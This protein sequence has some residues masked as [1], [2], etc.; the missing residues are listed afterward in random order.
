MNK[1]GK[2]EKPDKIGADTIPPDLRFAVEHGIEYKIKTKPSGDK[3]SVFL[4]PP[5]RLGGRREIEPYSYRK[6]FGE[7][8][9][10]K[11]ST[12]NFKTS[13]IRE[14]RQITPIRKSTITSRPKTR[15]VVGSLRTGFEESI[16]SGAFRKRKK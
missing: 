11:K 14:Q 8:P 16:L 10:M 4:T 12:S 2:P 9:L 1:N 6:R 13:V 15:M 3:Y 5:S 7:F